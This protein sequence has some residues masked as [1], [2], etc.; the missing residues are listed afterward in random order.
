MSK[1]EKKLSIEENFQYLDE[2]LKKMKDQNITLEESFALYEKGMEALKN[3]SAALDEVEKKVK[4]IDD[5]GNTED[6]Q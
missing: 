3:A 5:S 2:V 6:F 4:M 1:E